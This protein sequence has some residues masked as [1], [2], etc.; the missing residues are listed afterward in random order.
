[1]SFYTKVL[2]RIQIKTGFSER[3]WKFSE[4]RVTRFVVF[5]SRVGGAG[6]SYIQPV[7]LVLFFFIQ[8]TGSEAQSAPNTL[9]EFNLKARFI[10]NFFKYVDWPESA[11]PAAGQPVR[12]G[13]LGKSPFTKED[14]KRIQSKKTDNHPLEVV[15]TKKVEEV[16]DCSLV[17]ICRSEDRKL[18]GIL[19]ELKGRPLL[20]VGETRSFSQKGGMIRFWIGKTLHIEINN[21]STDK[22]RL[23]LDP[24]FLDFSTEP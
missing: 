5:C 8:V 19:E 21:T 3:E 20:T 22:A 12:I 10:V 13:V 11:I 16:L 9:S 17:F 18:S 7:L 14:I 15:L 4:N 1:M 24:Y 6:I 2:K 23:K